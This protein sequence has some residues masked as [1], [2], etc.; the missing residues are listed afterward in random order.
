MKIEYNNCY[1]YC[2][3]TPDNM[4]YLWDLLSYAPK[5]NRYIKQEWQQ[6]RSIFNKRYNRFPTGLLDYILNKSSL[7]IDIIDKRPDA[8]FVPM[9]KLDITIELRDYQQ[10]A[11]DKIIQE[12]RGIIK[13]PTG[14]GKTLLAIAATQILNRKT[15]FIVNRTDLAHQTKKEYEAKAGIKAGFIGDGKCD[16]K[17]VNVATIQSLASMMKKNDSV[18]DCL[19]NSEFIIFDEVHRASNTYQ[20]VSSVMK[21]AR[22]RIGLSA[23]A[24]IGEKEGK[25]RSQA[26]TGPLI[27]EVKMK[28]LVDKKFI[29][30]PLVYFINNKLDYISGDWMYVYENN[31]V[32][33]EER[34]LM[35]CIA[36]MAM[37]K[38]GRSSLILVERKEHG[39]IL[40][41]M[42]NARCRSVYVDGD[43]SSDERKSVLSDLQS[44]VIDVLI[45]TKIFNEGIDIP[46]L[47]VVIV[48]AGYK[49]EA[50]SIQRYGRGIRKTLFKE[51][52]TIIDFY[53]EQFYI[54]H[55]GERRNGLL[56]NHALQRL[57]A[58]KKD[59]A[60]EVN[61]VSIDDFL[62]GRIK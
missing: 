26:I 30:K 46:L 9:E 33:N 18:L 15:L 61:I 23:T 29:A 59:K 28:K 42:L 43:A 38:K 49:K 60:F 55:E 6:K 62:E 8:N 16:I 47:E 5:G 7:K 39:S 58:C 2:H 22:W 40:C 37:L 54:D 48:A 1:A 57:K 32:H 51:E 44:G 50:L 24:L 3:G 41:D 12:S 31:I 36:A 27:Y 21:M 4:D 11:V 17:K 14:A 45:S 20:D 34:N 19:L 35:V 53:D 25:L 52:T 13:I 56:H 10:I